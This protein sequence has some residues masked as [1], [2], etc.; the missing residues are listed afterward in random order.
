MQFS[1]TIGL[2]AGERFA[3][4]TSTLANYTDRPAR[5][6]GG[7]IM[8][9]R[10]GS[11]RMSVDVHGFTM[12]E[13]SAVVT[14][15]GKILTLEK[16]DDDFCVEYLIFSRELFEE[17]SFRMDL[18]FFRFLA[19]N[20]FCQH[21]EVSIE[22]FNRWF[23]SIRQLYEDRSHT[24]RDTIMKNQLQNVFLHIYDSLRRHD[25]ALN[26]DHTGR[27]SELFH[28]Y[29][30][31]VREHFRTQH[32]V[33]FYAG[34]MCITTRYLSTIVRNVSG[35]SPKDVIDRMMVLE[36]KLLLRSTGL[37]IQEIASRLHFP[38]QSYMGR[39]FR[40]HTG[41][42]PSEYRNKR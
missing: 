12:R 6:E 17:A 37:S 4:G 18:T 41:E 42:S 1:D 29:V 8:I 23:G 31:L 40:K 38:D 11:A 21:D 24:F 3:V 39:Y 9:C 19:E 5:I 10:R 36:M 2:V 20:P 33:S 28:K 15:P 22:R 25:V 26:E 16:A 27:Q 35:E 34:Q 32:N 30:S 14:L 13:G 7:V